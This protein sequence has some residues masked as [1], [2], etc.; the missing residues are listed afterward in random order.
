MQQHGLHVKTKVMPEHMRLSY[1]F[2][3]LMDRQKAP[4]LSLP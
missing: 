1:L 2:P 4:Y 3:S